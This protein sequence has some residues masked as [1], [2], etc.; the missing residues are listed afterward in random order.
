[1]LEL[2]PI[3]NRPGL[4][5][6]TVDHIA[7]ARLLFR[8]NPDR[9]TLTFLQRSLRIGYNQAARLMEHLEKCGVVSAMRQNGTRELLE[10]LDC[11]HEWTV[12]HQGQTYMDQRCSKCGATK[13]DTWD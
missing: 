13:R 11:A 1:M 10:D 7:A 2:K 12:T 5:L 3:L 6:V 9:V 4:S 8:A